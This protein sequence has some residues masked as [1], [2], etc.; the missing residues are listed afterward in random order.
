VGCESFELVKIDHLAALFQRHILNMPHDIRTWANTVIRSISGIDVSEST[1]WDL[2]GVNRR[3][4]YNT[5]RRS[6]LKFEEC[7]THARES[8]LNLR[9]DIVNEIVG[10]VTLTL[11]GDGLELEGEL[12]QSCRFQLDQVKKVIAS[13]HLELRSHDECVNLARLSE[14]DESVFDLL[15]RGHFDC[16]AFDQFLIAPLKELLHCTNNC[17]VD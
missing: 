9:D 17:T 5:V 13:N 14:S 7:L 3:L 10:I 8:T 2:L 6:N 11:N 1:A 4:L 15:S 16:C 12:L